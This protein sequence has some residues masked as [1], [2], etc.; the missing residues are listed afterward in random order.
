MYS[1]IF[2]IPH[3]D[4]IVNGKPCSRDLRKNTHHA[5]TLHIYKSVKVK[6]KHWTFFLKDENGH[7]HS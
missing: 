5:V 4:V 7:F 6:V 3:K 1:P 2:I